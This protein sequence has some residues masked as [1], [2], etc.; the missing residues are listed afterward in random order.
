[1]EG[2]EIARMQAQIDHCTALVRET[3]RDRYLATLFAPAEHRDALMAL[4][5]FNVEIARVREVAREPM[6]GEIRLQ[7]WREVLSGERGGEAAAH[8]VAT[9]L[10]AALL[11][12]GID[13]KRLT[14][15]IDAHGFDL[16]DDPMGTLDDLDAYGAATQGTLLDTA[17]AILGARNETVTRHAGIALA[18]AA[19]FTEFPRHASRRQ[20]YIPVEVLERHNADRE[21]IFAGEGSDA[22]RL[23]FAELIRHAR[24]QLQA[25]QMAMPSAPMLP[26]LLPAALVGPQLRNVERAGYQ[27]FQPEPLSLL[28]RQWLLWR[29]A[30]NP[31][32]IF[33]V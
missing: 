2:I 15:L 25:A 19:L 24:R 1:M 13:S 22:L 17:A 5:A 12:H 27:P 9:A 23:A 26:A 31:R 16:Y 28:R 14:T 30:R 8:P 3:D 20:L 18:I 21:R 10:L 4:Y 6:P 11:K 32:R 7:W 29:A 33:A